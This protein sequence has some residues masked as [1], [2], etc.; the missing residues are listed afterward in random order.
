MGFTC[1]LLTATDGRMCL[2][3]PFGNRLQTDVLGLAWSCHHACGQQLGG[4]AS[5]I[6]GCSQP[7]LK[8]IRSRRLTETEVYKPLPAGLLAVQSSSMIDQMRECER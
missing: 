2:I 1:F 8:A 7:C 4:E 6:A 5:K 3:V